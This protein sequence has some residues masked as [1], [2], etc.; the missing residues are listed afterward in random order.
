MVLLSLFFGQNN[1]LF[2]FSVKH[3]ESSSGSHHLPGSPGSCQSV[4]VAGHT[5]LSS[6]GHTEACRRSGAHYEELT[7]EGSWSEVV[8][9]ARVTVGAVNLKYKDFRQYCIVKKCFISMENWTF[10]F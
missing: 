2:S 9:V 7:V 8:A 3:V 4:R 10:G 5:Y 1:F 6:K